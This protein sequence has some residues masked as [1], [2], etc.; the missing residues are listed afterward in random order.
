[1]LL[2]SSDKGRFRAKVP[3][4]RCVPFKL[5]DTRQREDPGVSACS[6][7]ERE[8]QRLG[9]ATG[10]PSDFHILQIHA[11]VIQADLCRL[12]SDILVLPVFK[13]YRT[14]CC[15]LTLCLMPDGCLMY[16]I[17]IVAVTHFRN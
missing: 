17:L 12:S 8:A 15:C 4:N 14:A 16:E 1:M 6:A 11:I 3:Y 13:T 10:H 2:Y 5:R 7:T 9:E